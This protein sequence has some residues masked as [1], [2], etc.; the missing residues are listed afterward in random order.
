MKRILLFIV[1]FANLYEFNANNSIKKETLF[2]KVSFLI[3]E[4]DKYYS[5]KYFRNRINFLNMKIM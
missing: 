2:N 4:N 1:V 5:K 3:Q